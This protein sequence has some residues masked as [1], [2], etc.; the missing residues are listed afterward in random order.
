MRRSLKF[1]SEN[2]TLETPAIKKKIHSYIDMLLKGEHII[3]D[4][5]YW[6]MFLRHIPLHTKRKS[7]GQ[8]TKM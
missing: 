5:D 7:F 2:K 4:V 3:L 1:Y 8:S 6:L